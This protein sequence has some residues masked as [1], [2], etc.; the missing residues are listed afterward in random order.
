MNPCCATLG[1][2][3]F[4]K[5]PIEGWQLLA[6]M[7]SGYAVGVAVMLLHRRMNRGAERSGDE[8]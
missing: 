6:A 8:D 4:T 5:E 3:L 7:L 1:D 2:F